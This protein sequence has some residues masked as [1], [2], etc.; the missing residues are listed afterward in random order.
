MAEADG[1]LF[2]AD[3]NIIK[4][5]SKRQEDTLAGIIYL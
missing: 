5:E 2:L 4:K 1:L 3:H